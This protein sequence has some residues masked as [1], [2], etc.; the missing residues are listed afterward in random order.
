MTIS[1]LAWQRVNHTSR[2]YKR[3]FQPYGNLFWVHKNVFDLYSVYFKPKF[4]LSISEKP[5]DHHGLHCASMMLSINSAWCISRCCA[6]TCKWN[7]LAAKAE[8]NLI[9]IWI[10]SQ[11]IGFYWW[12]LLATITSQVYQSLTPERI[13]WQ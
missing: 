13:S 5:P 11:T 6:S 10:V 1:C 9:S 8:W 4:S 3:Y 2:S 7:S 12:R